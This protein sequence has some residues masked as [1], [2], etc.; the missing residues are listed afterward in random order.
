M[1]T[2]FITMSCSEEKQLRS[3]SQLKSV[4]KSLISGNEDNYP[5]SIHAYYLAVDSSGNLIT[6]L[7]ESEKY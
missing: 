4:K 5:R 1:M 3:N 6:D 2:P 7:Q